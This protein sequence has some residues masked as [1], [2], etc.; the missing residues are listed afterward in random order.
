[1]MQWSCLTAATE[2][3]KGNTKTR[4]GKEKGSETAEKARGVCIPWLVIAESLLLL[5]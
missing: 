1:M 2:E 5:Y 4:R 3:S